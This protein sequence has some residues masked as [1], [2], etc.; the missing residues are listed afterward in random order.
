MEEK[1][2][3]SMTFVNLLGC[4]VKK[5]LIQRQVGID[6]N[7]KKVQVLLLKDQDISWKLEV[8]DNGTFE[9]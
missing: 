5:Q 1:T 3:A 8:F 6:N 7:D 4:P 9:V 2:S